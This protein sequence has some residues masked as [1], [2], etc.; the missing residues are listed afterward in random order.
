MSRKTAG[1]RFPCCDRATS[2]RYGSVDSKA[3]KALR[4]PGTLS[5]V[6]DFP[7]LGSLGYLAA[8]HRGQPFVPDRLLGRALRPSGRGLSGDRTDNSKTQP[9]VARIRGTMRSNRGLSGSWPHGGR[10]LT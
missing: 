5:A 2:R 1:P 4:S 6:V 7:V 3:S 9:Q 8:G 10:Y